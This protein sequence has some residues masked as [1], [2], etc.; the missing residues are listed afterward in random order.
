[1]VASTHWLASAAGMAVLEQG[2]NAFDAAVAA[3][4]HAAGRRAAPERAGRRSAGAPLARRRRARRLVRAGAGAAGRDDH[5]V[6]R[7][8]RARARARDGTARGGRARLVRRLAHDAAR[9]RDAAARR[10]AAVR[11]RLRGG[12]LSR[13][14]ADRRRDSQR[15]SALPRRVDDLGGALPA[16][17]RAGHAAPKPAARC[18]VPADP[19]RVERRHR[20][21]ARLLVSRLRRR[22]VRGLPGA[23]VAGQLRRAPRG[24]AR[25]GGP[26]RLAADLR[27][28]A[29]GRLPRPQRVEGGAVEPGAGVPAAAAP[30]R[31]LRSR[32][33]G[34]RERGVRPHDHR[35]REARVR[36]SRG[37]VRRPGVLRR[38]D[39]PAALACLRGRA[40]RARR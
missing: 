13:G 32:R 35:V 8:A 36:G 12:G 2:G 33:D 14:A 17:A 20:R 27:A 11:D 26:A 40:A 30:A 28:A 31:R 21:G 16:R 5:A 19:R 37:V 7:R 15:R 3:G 6:S 10:G 4:L 29:R 9:L 38:A 24:P 34:T 39:G 23:G 25:G 18:D 22:G 1:M